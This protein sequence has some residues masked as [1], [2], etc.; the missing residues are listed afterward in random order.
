MILKV[1]VKRE[2]AKV[3]KGGTLDYS[4]EQKEAVK[5]LL[6][7]GG[8]GREFITDSM[9]ERLLDDPSQVDAVMD[10]YN[11]DNFKRNI[12]AADPGMTKEFVSPE[13][14]RKIQNDEFITRTER[15]DF[16]K[17]LLDE[18]SRLSG[19]MNSRRDE[20]S[21][22]RSTA[23]AG[24][25]GARAMLSRHRLWRNLFLILLGASFGL[26]AIA[27][28][29]EF[30][31]REDPTILIP[32]AIGLV[33]TFIIYKIVFK[34]DPLLFGAFDKLMRE[35]KNLEDRDKTLKD[36]IISELEE[37]QIDHSLEMSR[38]ES[39]VKF[40]RQVR[41]AIFR[42]AEAQHSKKVKELEDALNA[43]EVATGFNEMTIQELKKN[44]ER[45]IEEKER[46]ISE[47]AEN[48]ETSVLVAALNNRFNV[49]DV[50]DDTMAR[51]IVESALKAFPNLKEE[52]QALAYASEEHKRINQYETIMQL[53]N[54]KI[55]KVRAQEMDE[56]DRDDAIAHWKRLRD[57]EIEEL[58]RA[59][60]G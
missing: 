45:E 12:R 38:G 24:E 42:H 19:S 43:Q 56:E 13:L 2:L 52:V 39:F 59:S 36:I 18:K 25:D 54:E 53:Y 5:D 33:S 40:F 22:T 58:T 41:E 34:F 31:E 50:T 7:R 28:V 21:R 11:S 23:L 51:S 44:H 60:D 1:H 35:A 17:K 9:V 29:I 32:V 26:G 20:D 10:E 37:S 47:G 8:A 14:M 4:R 49:G 55:A 15:E 46:R 48:A 16:E 27:G 6:E 3:C 30:F 57:T